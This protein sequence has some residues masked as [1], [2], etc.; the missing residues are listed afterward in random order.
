MKWVYAA[1]I[2]TTAGVAQAQLSVVPQVPDLSGYAKTTDVTSAIASATPPPCSAPLPDTLLGSAGS[3]PTCMTRPDAT[4]PT[5]IQAT[6]VVTASDG[7]FVGTWP[8]PFA[9][10]PTGRIADI[11]VA[12]ANAAPYKCS[13]ISSSVTATGFSGKCWQIV[14][15]TLPTTA[16]ALLG[17]TVSPIQNAAAGLTV[18]VT[19]RQ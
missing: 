15:T 2:L 17:L 16:T 6:S 11:E 4:R 19:G 3:Q 14:A 8:T 12:A 10:T 13:F 18:R 5:L 9:Y 1:L 7:T